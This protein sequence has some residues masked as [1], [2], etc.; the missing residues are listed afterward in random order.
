MARTLLRRRILFI[1]SVRVLFHYTILVVEDDQQS[2]EGLGGWLVSHG[3]AV[4]TALNVVEALRRIKTGRHDLAIIDIHLPDGFLLG[5]DGWDLA[6]I[7]R[8]YN[9]T[10]AVIV[11]SAEE[12]MVAK[13]I[14]AKV[15][16]FL[17]KPIELAQ[18]QTMLDA[19][20]SGPATLP[21]TL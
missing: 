19:L 7:F 3:Y 9:P 11:V 14:R 17:R 15:D 8:A 1:I 20:L 13:D 16:G 4:E 18:L 12:V 5:L 10:G 21:P 6:R 2:R